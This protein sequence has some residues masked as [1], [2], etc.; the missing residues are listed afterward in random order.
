MFRSVAVWY[1]RLDMLGLCE[2]VCGET[3]CGRLGEAWLVGVCFGAA[4]R[5]WVRQAWRGMV[6][7]VQV[8][9]CLASLVVAGQASFVMV[10]PGKAW[11]GKLG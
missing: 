4:R 2:A 5:G 10:S 11:F 9:L 1:G 3:W 8:R 6:G 7:S